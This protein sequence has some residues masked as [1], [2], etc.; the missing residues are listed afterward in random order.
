MTEPIDPPWTLKDIEMHQQ[1]VRLDTGQDV[2]A[3]MVKLHLFSNSPSG[4]ERLTT[5][6]PWFCI[7]P[8]DLP[9]VIEALQRQCQRLAAKQEF[10][11]SPP[12]FLQ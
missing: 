4:G 8:L 6:T 10:E 9:I 11:Q 12:D 3:L 7:P 2:K 5:A 1:I